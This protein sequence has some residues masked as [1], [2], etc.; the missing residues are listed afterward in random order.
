MAD[1]RVQVFELTSGTSRSAYEKLLNDPRVTVT[2]TKDFFTSI[3][4]GPEEPGYTSI[5]RVVDYRLTDPTGSI[6]DGPVC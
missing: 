1:H 3:Q 2:E 6:P 4:G 5:Q